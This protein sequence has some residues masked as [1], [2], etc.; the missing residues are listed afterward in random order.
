MNKQ[1]V[2]WPGIQNDIEKRVA[3]CQ[4]CS[5]FRV[6]GAEPLL[7]SPFPD[8]PLALIC[9]NGRGHPILLLSTIIPDISNWQSYHR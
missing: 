1:S 6:Q 9:W 3:K 4:V 2:W 7:P 8:G 5:K